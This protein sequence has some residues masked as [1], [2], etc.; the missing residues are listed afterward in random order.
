MNSSNLTDD[1]SRL[2]TE[3]ARHGE[4]QEIGIELSEKAKLKQTVIQSLLEPPDLQDRRTYTQRLTEAAQML[5]VSV[6]TVRWLM[7]KAQK[8]GLESL[9]RD[10][11]SADK[12]KFRIATHWQ[13]FIIETYKDGN[14]DGKHITPTQVVA[15]VQARAQDLG[16]EYYPH[17]STVYRILR[18]IAKDQ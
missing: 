12:G 3:K 16:Q 1:Q 5:G 9:N 11:R 10:G 2:L 14:Q 18:S 15:R 8:E 6:Q 13:D 4:A 7:A 17:P